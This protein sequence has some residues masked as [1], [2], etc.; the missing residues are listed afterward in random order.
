MTD[1][2]ITKACAEAMGYQ[3]IA[4]CQ[5]ARPGI[6]P[7]KVSVSKTGTSMDEQYAPLHDDAQAMALVKKFEL[8]IG[9]TVMGDRW[10][11]DDNPYGDYACVDENLNRAICERIVKMK[12]KP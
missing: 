2:E 9:R 3:R 11:V 10:Y 12:V 8:R 7:D 5:L 4:H 6:E 1:L